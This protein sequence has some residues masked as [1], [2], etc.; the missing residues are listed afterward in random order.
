MNVHRTWRA[1]VAS[2]ALAAGLAFG[3][4]HA[5]A[6]EVPIVTGEHWTRSSADVKK[7]YLVGIANVLQIESAYEGSNPPSNLQSL[8]PTAAKA[9]RGESLDSVRDK[10]DRWYAQ[11][12]GQLAR[13]VFEVIWFEAVVPGYAKKG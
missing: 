1:C 6:D 4:G 5:L 13:P 10:V 3:A 9:L 12:P 7:A 2:I 11:N 8:I